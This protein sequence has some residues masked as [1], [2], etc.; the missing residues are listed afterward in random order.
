MKAVFILAAMVLLSHFVLAQGGKAEPKRIEFAPGK[1]S[2]ALSGSLRGAQEMEYVFA[3]KKGQTVTVK[4]PANGAFDFR[5]FSNENEVETEFDSSPTLTLDIP[6]DGDYLFF[7]R[8]KVGRGL[9]RF[10]MTLT[11]R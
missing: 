7:V 4:N 9:A 6:A 11:V 3:V 1:N 10:R 5:I 8:R 2:A